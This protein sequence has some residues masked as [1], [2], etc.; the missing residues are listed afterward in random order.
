VLVAANSL[1]D[2]VAHFL[3]VSS[4]SDRLAKFMLTLETSMICGSSCCVQDEK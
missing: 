1:R 3:A 4:K 2:P